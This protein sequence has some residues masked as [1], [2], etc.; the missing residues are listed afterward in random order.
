MKLAVQIPILSKKTASTYLFIFRQLIYFCSPI[1]FF[2]RM[3]QFKL[4]SSPK[5]SEVEPIRINAPEVVEEIK[6]AMEKGATTHCYE[7][8]NPIACLTL[9]DFFRD[10]KKDIPKAAK[11]RL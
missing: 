5:E 4:G 10:D 7:K 8:A 11:E 3:D 1:F 6:S 9:S 2:C